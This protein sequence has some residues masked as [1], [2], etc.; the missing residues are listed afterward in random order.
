MDLYKKYKRKRKELKPPWVYK[1][2]EQLKKKTTRRG[3]EHGPRNPV[4]HVIP[5]Q[6]V[7]FFEMIIIF[8]K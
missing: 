3:E 2:G 4:S 6:S 8:L 7:R 5:K 1:K